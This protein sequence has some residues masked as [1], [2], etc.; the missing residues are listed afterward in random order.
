MKPEEIYK[1]PAFPVM[2]M[3]ILGNVLSRADNPGDLGTYLTEEVR[4]LTGARCVLL[5]QCPGTPT[6]TAHRVV[7]VNPL[8]RREWAE[9][10]AGNRLYEVVHRVPSAQLWRGEEPSEVA[11]LLRQEGFELSM[12]FPLHAGEFRVGAMLVLGLPDEEHITSVLSLLNNLS[13]IVDLVLRNAILYEKQ[14]QII[15]E[16]TLEM[17][18]SN[19]QLQI[20]LEER[21]EAERR[22][23]ESEERLRLTLEATNIG[24]F[25]WDLEHDLWYATPTWFTMLGY[26]YQ[27]GPGNRDE[28][29]E[30]VHPDDR[31]F[32]L[33]L[34][35]KMLTRDFMKYEYEAR[36]RHAD[37]AYRWIAVA[38]FGIERDDDGKVTRVLGIRTDVTE[39]KQAEE[40]LVM[41]NQELEQRV[42]ERTA[43]LRQRTEELEEANERLKEVD[44]L[45]SAFLDSMSHELRTP[46]NSIIGFSRI[47]HDEWAG[48]VNA[49]QKQNLAC[50]LSSGRHLLYM[51]ND[52]LDVTQI[53]AGKIKPVIEEFDLYDLL[54]EAEN[55]V[56]AT[57]REKGLEL[58]SQLLR[59]RMRTDR[60]RLLQCV[61]NIL[62]NA[63][64]FTDRGSVTVEARIVSSTGETPEGEMVEIAVTDTG[65]G[66]GEEDRSRIF[67]AFHRIVTPQRTIVPGTG[68]GLF[69]TR[70]IATEIL[71]GDIQVSSEY[72]KGSRFSLKIPVRLTRNGSGQS[73]SLSAG[74]SG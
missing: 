35:N 67:Q 10:P 53:E 59:Q 16:R 32:F 66:I 31:A 8:R 18:D 1:D 37:G 14:E 42:Y 7:S 36:I 15:R 4:D 41:L 52:V 12:V 69:L 3:D 54:V 5:I 74:S 51:I 34:T 27:P 62:N 65:I 64:K 29:L 68:I 60:R 2:A 72:G 30:R 47:L 28:W 24:I 22:L 9:S 23:K 71:K 44:R 49:E 40:E 61:L 50:I 57:M 46:L 48:P 11:G 13:A 58:R 56:A 19:S 38:G 45:K 25:D 21:K 6:V 43:L 17:Q 26:E 55:Q 33:E 70:K 20:E 39:R 63:A 73:G